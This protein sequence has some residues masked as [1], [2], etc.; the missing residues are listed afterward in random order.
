LAAIFFLQKK[1][2][3]GGKPVAHVKKNRKKYITVALR[4]VKKPFAI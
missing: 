4:F 2:V 3:T 1:S